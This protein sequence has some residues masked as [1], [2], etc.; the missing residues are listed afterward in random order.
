MT[1]SPLSAVL[2]L[3]RS[4]CCRVLARHA[5]IEEIF[6][7]RFWP[8]AV[9]RTCLDFT[10]FSL[11]SGTPLE[12][13]YDA[14]LAGRSIWHLIC[15]TESLALRSISVFHPNPVPSTSYFTPG[16]P[17]LAKLVMYVGDISW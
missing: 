13:F 5:T 11:S 10:V 1:V 7:G 15:G 17:D 16:C 14:H 6:K 12:W 2:H 8:P 4:D 3:V 9:A